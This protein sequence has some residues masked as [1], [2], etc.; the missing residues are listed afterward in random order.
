MKTTLALTVSL[1]ICAHSQLLAT[2]LLTENVKE[3]TITF[4]LT[5]QRQTS[6]SQTTAPNVGFWTN[7]PTHYQTGAVKITQT[8]IIRYIAV[9]KFGEANFYGSSPQLVLVQGELSGFFTM[10]PDLAA[11]EPFLSYTDTNAVP[12]VNVYDVGRILATNNPDFTTVIGSATNSLYQALA[13][14]RA[15]ETNPITKN[16]PVGHLQPWGQIYVKY[17]QRVGGTNT[18]YY[19]NVTFFFGLT[20]QECYDCFYLNSF[21]SDTAFSWKKTTTP[22]RQVGPPCCSVASTTNSVLLGSGHD[23]YFL[24]LNFDDTQANPYLNSTNILFSGIQGIA[25]D[26]GALDGLVPDLIS[27]HDSITYPSGNASPYEARF[28]LNGIFT[29]NWT[30]QFV[31][32]ADLYPDFVGS[33]SLSATGF[34][35]L[36][37]YCTLLTGSMSISERIVRGSWYYPWYINNEGDWSPTGYDVG[38]YSIGIYCD[39]YNTGFYESLNSDVIFF[40]YGFVPSTPFN[41]GANLTYHTGFPATYEPYVV[42]HRLDTSLP[43]L[44]EPV[45]GGYGGSFEQSPAP[46]SLPFVS[47]EPV[48]GN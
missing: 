1:A 9:T 36:Q 15:F 14:G 25:P 40:F 19:D 23:S 7:G 21:V 28:T 39:V 32:P 37:L 4:S 41:T 27:Y 13:N 16:N 47:I 44:G 46:L 24:T 18:T 42:G 11:A 6:V 10:T 48:S 29:Y 22:G 5:G 12:N 8:D 3:G 35:F 20:V 31:N 33:G 30:L 17:T 45:V 34:G 26:V 2:Q 43:S 38:W